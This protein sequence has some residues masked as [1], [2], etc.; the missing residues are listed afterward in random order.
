MT[1]RA[2]MILPLLLLTLELLHVPLL[3]DRNQGDH[4]ADRAD[5]SRGPDHTRGRGL[6]SSACGATSSRTGADERTRPLAT[7]QRQPGTAPGRVVIR[8]ITKDTA[9]RSSRRIAPG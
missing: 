1:M 5:G 9:T 4:A 6:S 2:T 3:R 7:A 8:R